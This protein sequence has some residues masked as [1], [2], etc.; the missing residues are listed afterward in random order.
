MQ[1]E[2][3]VWGMARLC[4]QLAVGLLAG[5][6]ASPAPRPTGDHVGTA[7]THTPGAWRTLVRER[8]GPP[9]PWA[10]MDTQMRKAHMTE[11]VMPAMLEL[12]VAF[13][14]TRY[15][16]FGCKTCHGAG[17]RTR[18][19]AMPSPSLPILFPSGSREQQQTV[20]ENEEMARFMFNA[21]TP[22][23]R[24]LLGVARYDKETG[25]GFSCFYCHPRGTPAEP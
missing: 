22:T 12:F 3:R 4:A 10:Q 21:V 16:T 8:E 6:C 9:Q 2:L 14:R 15:A 18:D 11:A 13:D 17:A 1:E 23:M 24:A 25:E 20:A 19:Y 7:P 5:A